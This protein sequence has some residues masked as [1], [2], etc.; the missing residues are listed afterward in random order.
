MPVQLME[1]TVLA[2]AVEALW[3]LQRMTAVD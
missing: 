3:R 1:L 2:L